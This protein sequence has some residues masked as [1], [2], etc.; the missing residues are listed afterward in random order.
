MQSIRAQIREADGRQQL[1]ESLIRRFRDPQVVE[2]VYENELLLCQYEKQYEN[3]RFNV[4]VVSKLILK[5]SKS[6]S[7]LKMTRL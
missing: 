5:L 1:R 3:L 4:N 2:T 6:S 7:I